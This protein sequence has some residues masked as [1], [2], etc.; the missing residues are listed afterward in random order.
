LQPRRYLFEAVDA[1]WKSTRELPVLGTTQAVS[2]GTSATTA[3]E[4]DLPPP[5]HMQRVLPSLATE[6]A[7]IERRSHR[8]ALARQALESVP[9]IEKYIDEVLRLIEEHAA[10]EDAERK[11]AIGARIETIGFACANL[12]NELL[13]PELSGGKKHRAKLTAEQDELAHDLKNLGSAM[14]GSASFLVD[15]IL[16]EQ[17]NRDRILENAARLNQLTVRFAADVSGTKPKVARVVVGEAIKWVHRQRSEPLKAAGIELSMSITPDLIT[18]AI[19]GDLERMID[20][21]VLNAAQAIGERGGKIAIDLSLKDKWI[22]V[23]V[24]D[25]GPGIPGPV[26][27]RL[28]KSKV[29]TKA[30]GNG[31][32]TRGAARIVGKLGGG[33]GVQSVLGEGASFFIRL[34]RYRRD[35]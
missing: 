11:S 33:I 17:V 16:S 28:F 2:T 19:P 10:I 35:D 24:T 32:G 8:S 22:E 26:L 12:F 9:K 20:N 34:P 21:F 6:P 3:V 7:T 31:L 30:D 14:A 18:L 4:I 15:R 1:G 25:D 13:H 29:T 5:E 27:R 23:R